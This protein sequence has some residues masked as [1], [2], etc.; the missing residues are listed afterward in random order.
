MLSSRP[1]Q[2]PMQE[3]VV[4]AEALRAEVKVALV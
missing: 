1:T 2:Q 3:Q 4:D